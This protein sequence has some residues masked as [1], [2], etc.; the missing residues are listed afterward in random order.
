MGKQEDERLL[1]MEKG[2][3]KHSEKLQELKNINDREKQKIENERIRI[4]N[5]LKQVQWNHEEKMKVIDPQYPIPI[6]EK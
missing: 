1:S 5:Q 6:I 2:K 3:N 4:D